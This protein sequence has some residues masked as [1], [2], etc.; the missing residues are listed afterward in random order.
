MTPAQI[1]EI[2]RDH[3][4]ELA[5]QENERTERYIEHNPTDSTKRRNQAIIYNQALLDVQTKLTQLN[6]QI[7]SAN[8]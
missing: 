6:K 4:G 1:I 8:Q 3:L 7:R 5:K 2:L